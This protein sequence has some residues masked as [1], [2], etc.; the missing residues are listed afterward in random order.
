MNLF[1]SWRNLANLH[2]SEGHLSVITL[3]NEV[4]LVELRELFH[5]REFASSDAF[6][7]IIAA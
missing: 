3:E 7:E 1:L 5:L 2:V 4:A 6:L